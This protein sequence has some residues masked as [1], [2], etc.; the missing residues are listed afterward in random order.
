MKVDK[1]IFIC[2]A[3]VLMMLLCINA[4]SATEP[5]NQTSGADIGDKIAINDASDDVLSVSGNDDLK[6]Q[7]DDTALADGTGD[8]IYVS[9]TGNNE[10]DGQSR[11]TAVRTI[12]KA[13]ELA[14]NGPGKVIILEGTYTESN[15]EIDKDKP[16]YIAGEG[17]VVIDGGSDSNSIF[18]MHGGEASFTNI[19]F[20]NANPSYGGAIFMNSESGTGRDV[21][22]VNVLVDN[23]TFDELKTTKR[24]GAIY[25]W[26]VQGDIIIERSNFY[27]MNVSQWG[28]A[29]CVGYSPDVNVGIYG[30]KFENNSANN[31]GGVYLQANEV[32]MVDSTFNNNSATYDSGAV[33]L[34]DSIATADKCVLTNNKAGSEGVAVKFT[35]PTSGSPSVKTL[36]VTNSVIENNSATDATLPAIY[37][38]MQTLYISYSSLIN[39]ISIETRTGQGYGAVYGQ[40]IA[41]ANNNWWNTNDPTAKVSGKNITV[42]RWV[43]MNVEASTSQV[44]SGDE[45]TLTV[46]FNH[47]NTTSGVLEE[48]SGGE[49]PKESYD[50]KFTAVNGTV[51][52]ETLTVLKGEVKQATFTAAGADALVNVKSGEASEDIVFKGQSSQNDYHGIIYVDVNGDDSQEGSINA[53]VS[54]I[55][56]AIELA[57]DGLGQIVINEGTYKGNMYHVTKAL[58]VTGNGN[59][60]L[61]ADGGRLFTMEY[62]D[63]ADWLIFRQPD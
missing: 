11:E 30:S 43:V 58:N 7:L 62:G 55:A 39:D 34:Y 4:S 46:D 49:I 48:L 61:D 17:N 29:V 22:D 52:P 27:N 3:I 51:E 38:D 44:E 10:S 36:T 28:G 23:C 25:A 18:V 20:T 2:T 1:K 26:Y 16:I 53:P 6:N 63:S 14:N 31:G 50:V 60:V 47:V 32:N 19:K 37:V 41:V 59:V 40:G 9:V 56:K 54:S 5:L 21:I 15:I 45:V 8:A 33:Y 13:V 12:A 42:D 24:G 35:R 57:N